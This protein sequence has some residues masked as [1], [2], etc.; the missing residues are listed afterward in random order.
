M[1]LKHQIIAS[2]RKAHATELRTAIHSMHFE[3]RN[4]LRQ[5]RYCLKSRDYSAVAHHVVCAAQWKAQGDEFE[6][7]LLELIALG[8]KS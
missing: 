4:S 1:S 6:R 3:E 2:M 7:E 8:K 5:I